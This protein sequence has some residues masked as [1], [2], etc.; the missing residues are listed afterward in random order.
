MITDEQ[1]KK[2]KEELEKID[3]ILLDYE[4]NSEPWVVINYTNR[5]GIQKSKIEP[6]TTERFIEPLFKDKIVIMMSAT[7]SKMEGWEYLEVSSPF[8]V[9]LRQWQYLPLGRMSMKHRMK[10]FPKVA[11]WLPTLTGKTLVHCVSYD[12]ASYLAEL[13]RAK[14][15]YPL[16]QTNDLDDVDED[17]YMRYDIVQAFKTAKDQ[18]KILLSVKLERGTDFPEPDILNNVILAVPFPNP[19]DPLTKAKNNTIGLSWQDSQVARTIEQSY[20]R[21]NRN[22]D[23]KT[24]TYIVDS[25]FNNLELGFWYQRNL[26]HFHK[27]FIEAE[28]GYNKTLHEVCDNFNMVQ[29]IHNGG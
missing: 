24:M 21:I 27:W 17:T 7:L 16:L 11:E 2:Y 19:T 12:S 15:I 28:V 1:R 25:N 22:A 18:D 4:E 10:S 23:K 8:P 14:G 26:N 20:G 5:R 6:I 9:E 29:K 3:R 13:L